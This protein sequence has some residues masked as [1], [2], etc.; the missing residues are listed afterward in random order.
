M[1]EYTAMEA[2]SPCQ[3]NTT[4]LCQEQRDF[5]GS[6]PAQPLPHCALAVDIRQKV[7][8]RGT[9]CPSVRKHSRHC[10]C[11]QWTGR[12]GW[13]QAVQTCVKG[14]PW[15]Q[16]KQKPDIQKGACRWLCTPP[17]SLTL[18]PRG[19]VKNWIQSLT[20][21]CVSLLRISTLFSLHSAFLSQNYKH[22]FP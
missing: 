8:A 10:S 4:A 22:R 13:S 1:G 6:R 15:Y 19:T 14:Q 3:D 9:L 20:V 17:Q 21:Q 18:V 7:K 11:W 5:W 12:R 2:V 16:I